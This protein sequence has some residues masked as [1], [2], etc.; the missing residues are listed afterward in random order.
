MREGAWRGDVM[1]ILA[2][3]MWAV[4]GLLSRHWN[5]D[6]VETTVSIG[7]LSLLSVPVWALIMPMQLADASLRAI[8]LQASYQGAIVGVIALFLYARVV[9]LIGPVRAALFLP[10]V[11][12]VAAIGA[13]LVLGERPSEW[14]LLGM[15]IVVTGMVAT[16]RP[17]S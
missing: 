1:F 13:W 11:P 2:A 17:T 6:P 15:L 10:V 7:V 3:V 9:I 8:V 4:F 5:A 14:E 12:C 16:L